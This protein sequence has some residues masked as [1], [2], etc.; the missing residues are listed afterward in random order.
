[1]RGAKTDTPPEAAQAVRSRSEPFDATGALGGERQ[2]LPRGDTLIRA[3]ESVVRVLSAKHEGPER[4]TTGGLTEQASKHRAR[5]AEETADLRN[6]KSGL[7]RCG[8][9]SRSVGPPGPRRPAP[10]SRFGKRK[11]KEGEA[12]RLKSRRRSVG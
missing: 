1:M 4:A 8:D 12:R 3:L 6:L 7:P 2:V 10:P 11:S 5:D 9:A